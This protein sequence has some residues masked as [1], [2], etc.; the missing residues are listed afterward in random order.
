[1]PHGESGTVID[2]K[3]LDR[4]EGDELD[5]G[6]LK[7]I[8]VRV[9][10][11]RKIK[12]GDK[13]AGRHGNKGVISKIVPIADMPHL[14][15]GTPVDIII[16]PLSVLARMNLGQLFEAHLGWAAQKL[17]YKVALPVFEKFDEQQIWDELEKAGLPSDGKVQLFDGRTGEAYQ[18]RTAAGVAYIL[19]LVHMVDDKVH[20]RSTGP[21]SLVTQQPLGG[22]AQMGGQ[23]L[24]EMEVWALESHKAAYS[25]QEMLTIKSDDISGRAKAFK[26]MVK[27]LPIPPPNIPESFRV[28]MREL[29]ALGLDVTPLDLREEEEIEEVA[30]STDLDEDIS[31]DELADD[32]NSDEVKDANED[33]K[34]EAIDEEQEPSVDDLADDSD[35]SIDEEE[36]LLDQ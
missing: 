27:G 16:S 30:E 33:E 34:P 19:K 21:Y 18:E 11:K 9:A 7:Q 32:E 13:L 26:A 35:D 3:V 6:V 31:F 24:G 23:R 12:V 20:A 36:E 1:M 5:P 25:L 22:K 4:D 29:N 10:E 17:G 8:S 15:D 2:V 28:L 14:E